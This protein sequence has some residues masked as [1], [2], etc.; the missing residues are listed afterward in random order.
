MDMLELVEIPGTRGRD[1]AFKV[2]NKIVN[3][4]EVSSDG[5]TRWRT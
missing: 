2:I 4:H 3:Y 5:R 1:P